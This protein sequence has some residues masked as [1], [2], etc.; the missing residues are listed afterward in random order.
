MMK[1]RRQATAVG[2]SARTGTETG[3]GAETGTRTMRGRRLGR[4]RRPSLG[5]LASFWGLGRV[6]PVTTPS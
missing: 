2:E 6:Y 3:T 1:V 4:S 5:S